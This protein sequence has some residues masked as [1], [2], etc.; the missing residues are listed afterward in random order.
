V[1]NRTRVLVV[2]DEIDFAENVAKLLKH[3]GFDVET[4]HNG[5]AALAAIKEGG[6]FDAVLLDV[7]M[8]GMDGIEVLKKL[9]TLDPKPEVIMLTGQATV[10]TGIE[11]IRAGAFDYLIKPCEIEDL[12]EKLRSVTDLVQIRK[13]PILWPR[14]MV[15][16]VVMYAFHRLTTNDPLTKALELFNSDRRKM[17]GE[18]FFIVDEENTLQGTITQQALVDAA[19]SDNPEINVTWEKLREHPELLPDLSIGEIMVPQVVAFDSETP[20]IAAAQSM[21]EHRMQSMP[22]IDE[23]RVV[24]I[25]RFRDVLK[26]LDPEEEQGD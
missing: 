7:K 16:E 2:D 18:I 19:A 14:S 12:T 5:A 11:A 3:R 26:Y 21:I 24:G 8:P 10:E 20:L 22:V 25:V 15:G 13:H 23:G 9:K 6:S 1:K 17:A 4:A